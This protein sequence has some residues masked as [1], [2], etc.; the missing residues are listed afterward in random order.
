MKKLLLLLIIAVSFDLFAIPTPSEQAL[1]EKIDFDF[2]T[3]IDA[4]EKPL[5]TKKYPLNLLCL[6]VGRVQGSLGALAILNAVNA[7]QGGKVNVPL[8]QLD[9][10]F[11]NSV[12]SCVGSNLS[13]QDIYSYDEKMVLSQLRKAADDFEAINF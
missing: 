12:S 8:Q 9:S 13:Q 7:A 11:K 5:F 10:A 1:I 6:N 3:L 2:S 4:V